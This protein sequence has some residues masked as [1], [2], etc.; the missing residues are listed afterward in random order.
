LEVRTLCKSNLAVQNQVRSQFTKCVLPIPAQEVISAVTATAG[1]R[2]TNT[3]G[4][5]VV[6]TAIIRDL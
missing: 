2:E 1:T 6:I 5:R 3:E 4:G